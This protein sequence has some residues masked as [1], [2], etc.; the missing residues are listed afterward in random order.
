MSWAVRLTLLPVRCYGVKH[1]CFAKNDS[2]PSF[3]FLLEIQ[4]VNKFGG[5]GVQ[6]FNANRP[7]IF[8]IEDETLG[9]MLFAGKIE[10]PVF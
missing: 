4:L 8:F 5:D 3:S 9:T 10:N 2:K 7:F 1:N 6:I